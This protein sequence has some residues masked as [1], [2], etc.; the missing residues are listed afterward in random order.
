VALV[1][2]LDGV[3]WLGGQ[4]IPGS[5]DAIATLRAGGHRVLFVTNNSASCVPEVERRLA[6]MG[7]PAEGD[8]VTSSIAAASLVEAGERVHV[9]GETGLREALEARGALLVDHGDADT[10]VVGRDTNFDFA[11][12][13]AAS[14]TIR[15]GAR[16]IATNDD[17]TFPT[18]H[19]LE[20][21]NGA[22]V[23]AVA[24]ASGR[25]PVVAGKPH[26]PMAKVVRD[27]LGGGDI[28]MVGDRPDTDGEFAV[29]LGGRF[30]LVLSGVTSRADLPVTPEP[31]LVA[32]DL[33]ALARLLGA[34]DHVKGA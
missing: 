24:T 18:A 32:D 9:V 27:L 11:M 20:P 26:A 5:A 28:T 14:A 17:S 12:L 2:D 13:A 29:A 33:A 34:Q 31:D 21:G 23:A 8:V 4:P 22:I 15:D 30:A 6:A 3:L 7:V 10:V 1:F 16:F 25:E 19:G